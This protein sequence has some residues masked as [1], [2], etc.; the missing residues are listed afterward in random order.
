[1]AGMKKRRGIFH[2]QNIY[3]SRQVIIDPYAQS[4]QINLFGRFQMGGL[5]QSMNSGIGSPGS[6][7]LHRHA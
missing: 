6:L 4:F 5:R 1:M 2:L 7:K 3:A